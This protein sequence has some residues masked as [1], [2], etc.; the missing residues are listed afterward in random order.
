MRSKEIFQTV[1]LAF[2]AVLSVSALTASVQIPQPAGAPASTAAQQT[3]ELEE[4][5]KLDESFRKFGTAAGAA[6]QCT[7]DSEKEKLVNEVRRAYSRIGQLF[8]T[9]RAFFF[10]THFGRG[11]DA[12]FDRARC[13]DLLKKIRESSLVRGLAN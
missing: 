4:D 1:V 6:Y 11:T 12:S 2:F 13:P 10:A 9:D 7:P 8:G 5:E 3:A